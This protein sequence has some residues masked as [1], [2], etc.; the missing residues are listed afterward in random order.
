[1]RPSWERALLDQARPAAP[2]VA[3]RIIHLQGVGGIR[4][5]QPPQPRSYSPL[6]ARCR[7]CARTAERIATAKHPQL[8]TDHRRAWHVHPRRHIG[9]RR[10]TVS[11]YVVIIQRVQ[12]GVVEVAPTSYVH[13][14]VDDPEAR[15]SKR[16]RHAHPAGV[17]G[18]G[19]WVVFPYLPKGWIYVPSV[20]STYQ[21][22]LPVKVARCHKRP[23]IRHRRSGTPGVGRDVVDTGGIDHCARVGAIATEH[24]EL[25]H[26][27]CIHP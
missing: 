2:R 7:H 6:V 27:G 8:A 22:D 23:H 3:S 14:P 19:H 18:V 12:I 13:V 20:I 17:K 10:P 11:R 25:V 15:A 4:T 26:I 21:V 9:P 1:M 5:E 24:E 16:R